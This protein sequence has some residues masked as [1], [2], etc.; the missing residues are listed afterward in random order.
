MP[1]A[2]T[3]VHKRLPTP[4]FALTIGI[5]H[6]QYHDDDYPDL[7]AAVGDA[8]EFEHF[9]KGSLGVPERNII[10]LRDEKA[11]REAIIGAFKSLAANTLI[12]RED[13]IVIF[14]SG[15]GANTEMPADW[16]EAGWVSGE[17]HIEM[18][19]PSDI[20]TGN[21]VVLG[22]PDRTIASL[23]NIISKAKGD[24]I[25]LILDCCHSAGINR[26][27][28]PDGL[29]PRSILHPPPIPADCDHDIHQAAP[30]AGNLAQ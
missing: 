4:I 3:Q 30:R 9:L 20:G 14:Y 26:S 5:N 11:T 27:E 29:V 25:T 21:P 1:V 2:D 19:C 6:Y 18:L 13:A 16:I 10:S 22:I 8:N 28:I 12:Q 7:N 23:L 15:H 24:N 17:T